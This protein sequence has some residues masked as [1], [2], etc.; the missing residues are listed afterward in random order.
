[1]NSYRVIY[2][3]LGLTT[4]IAGVLA[5]E[6]GLAAYAS[7]NAMQVMA[8][9]NYDPL[10]FRVMFDRQVGWCC[11]AFVVVACQ[12]AILICIKRLRRS[13]IP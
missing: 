7:H 10:P 13:S 5:F 8:T 6:A 3:A 2:C 4:V 12:A 9:T 1:M 11:D